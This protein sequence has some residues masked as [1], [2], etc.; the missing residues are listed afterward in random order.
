MSDIPTLERPAFFD[1]QLLEARD[2]MA[3]AEHQ[4]GLRWLHNR[5][6]HGWGVVRGAS[7]SG[8]RGDRAVLVSAGY[9][10]DCLGRELL[11]PEQVALPIPPVP[12]G[13]DGLPATYYLTVSYLDDHA[14]PMLEARGGVCA[15]SGAVR[16][17]ERA[18]LRWQSPFDAN[19]AT[20]YRRGLDVVLAVIEVENC[21][22]VAAP[23][24]SLRREIPLTPKPY[25]KTGISPETETPWL[26]YQAAGVVLGVEATIDT[27]VAG[28]A[29]T[30]LY[31]AQLMGSR[32]VGPGSPPKFVID[33][34]ATVLTPTASSFLIRVLLPPNINIT[35][36]TLNPKGLLNSQ[37]P[38]LLRTQLKWQVA[39]IG[40]EA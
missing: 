32:Q 12:R 40:I 38:N 18:R 2:L 31:N 39:W 8:K 17:P 9:A 26:L 37:L 22:L 35:P 27:S 24:A 36:Y 23:S 16:R 14:L 10:L 28:F 34:Y 19:P 21:R 33:G 20:Q 4:R 15:E 5:T 30:P 13:P 7:V 3:V 25:V 11:L 6:L 29:S 1:G